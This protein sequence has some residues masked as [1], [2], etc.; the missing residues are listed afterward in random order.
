MTQESIDLNTSPPR[1]NCTAGLRR[2]LPELVSN[3][4]FLC[5]EVVRPG[6][7]PFT[8]E[9]SKSSFGVPAEPQENL[10][11]TRPAWSQTKTLCEG[12]C[13]TR[14]LVSLTHY[15]FLMK[16]DGGA[17]TPISGKGVKALDPIGQSQLQ[18]VRG[19]LP[20]RPDVCSPEPSLSSPEP[21]RE[22]CPPLVPVRFVAE[23]RPGWGYAAESS[24]GKTGRTTRPRAHFLTSRD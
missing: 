5:R 7:L 23:R 20:A 9:L 10:L 15:T 2:G 22:P 24:G 13:S 11:I 3:G 1:Y 14:I 6:Q 4:R 21:V 19:S 16:G 17:N 8:N 18:G 12:C